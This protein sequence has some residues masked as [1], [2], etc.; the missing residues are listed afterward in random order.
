[1]HKRKLSLGLDESGEVVLNRQLEM[2]GQNWRGGTS[3][4][5]GSDVEEKWRH[6]GVK[7]AFS[8]LLIV[9]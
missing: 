5:L 3:E 7:E 2:R 9:G 1:M 6:L 4:G 8:H